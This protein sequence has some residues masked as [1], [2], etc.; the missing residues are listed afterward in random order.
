MRS[1][2]HLTS[3]N[4]FFLYG[5]LNDTDPLFIILF[6]CVCLCVSVCVCVGVCETGR[7]YPCDGLSQGCSL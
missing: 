7:K 5:G 1:A 2:F 4:E 6:V 3:K